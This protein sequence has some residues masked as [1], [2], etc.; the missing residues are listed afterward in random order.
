MLPSADIQNKVLKTWLWCIS[1]A[2]HLCTA[3]HARHDHGMQSA[4]ANTVGCCNAI[5]LD[6]THPHVQ[7]H[8]PVDLLGIGYM[9]MLMQEHACLLNEMDAN[10]GSRPLSNG[11]PVCMWCQLSC[12]QYY[13]PCIMHANHHIPQTSGDQEGELSNAI[14]PCHP[15]PYSASVLKT[16]HQALRLST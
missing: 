2:W 1:V 4:A 9:L 14:H 7:V 3:A 16:Q 12:R 13:M 6:D 10:Q 8:A 5:T 11:L 15:M